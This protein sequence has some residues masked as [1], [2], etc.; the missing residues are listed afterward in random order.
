MFT[1]RAEYRLLLREDNADI[2]L[3]EKGRDIGLISDGQYRQYREKKEHIDCELL[4]L[5]IVRVKQ[6]PEVNAILTGRG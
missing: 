5:K 4:R 6:T 3:R 2:R 1:S